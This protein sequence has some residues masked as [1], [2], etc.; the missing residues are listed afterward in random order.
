VNA[1]PATLKILLGIQELD[2]RLDRLAHDR[3]TLPELTSIAEI[4]QRLAALDAEAAEIEARRH[5]LGREQKRHEDEVA[6][7]EDRIAKEDAKLYSGSVTALKELQALQDEIASLNARRSTVEDHVLEVMEAIEPVDAELAVIAERRD[8]LT[9]ERAGFE[10]TVE[11]RRG[12]ID[13]EADS[14]RAQRVDHVAQL[15]AE[16]LAEYERLRARP[17]Q[18]GVARLVGTTCHGCHLDLSAV[19]ADRLKKL[20]ANDLVHCDE[21]GCILV[22]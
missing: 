17:G 14:V 3:T 19:E 10:Q 9:T 16:L 12:E 13:A 6:L 15:D 2:R 5:E 8:A 7:I 18:V 1:D 11:V 4:D 22:R 21:C 20:P